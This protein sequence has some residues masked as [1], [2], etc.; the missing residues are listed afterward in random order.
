MEVYLRIPHFGYL[1]P[2]P[3]SFIINQIIWFVLIKYCCCTWTYVLKCMALAILDR[4]WMLST[5]GKE[6]NPPLSVG[7]LLLHFGKVWTYERPMLH[8]AYLRI[9]SF[10]GTDLDVSRLSTDVVWSYLWKSSLYWYYIFY[11]EEAFLLIKWIS[12]VRVLLLKTCLY[13]HIS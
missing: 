10:C 5:T 4:M 6:W 3:S 7:L 1:Y 2:L 8:V 9:F 12:R 11:H 13:L